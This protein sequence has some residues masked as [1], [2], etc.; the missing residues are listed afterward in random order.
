MSLPRLFCPDLTAP[1]VALSAEESRHALRSL[2]LRP[3]DAVELFDGRGT[4]A[5][6]RLVAPGGAMRGSRA[7]VHAR[8]SARIEQRTGVAEPQ[9][10][11]TLVVAGCKGARLDWLVEKCTELGVSSL[12]LTTFERS[13][14]RCGP[15][16]AVRLRRTA[17]EACKQ[18]RREW[19]PR[20]DAC[21]DLS[22]ALAQC[23]GELLIAHPAP[24]AQPIGQWLASRCT[25]PRS[26]HELARQMTAVIGPE[27]GL[28]DSELERLRQAGGQMVSLGDHTLRVET[29]AMALVANWAARPR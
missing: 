14:V 29:A 12:L 5:L 23:R 1:V 4:V 7:G 26:S 9:E 13:V 17:L 22:A 16:H 28:T 2:R 6:A 20:I 18:C 10:V 27:G 3:G 25:L 19:L 8:A 15:Q 21:V 11:L 24:F